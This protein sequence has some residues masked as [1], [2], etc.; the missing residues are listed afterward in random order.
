MKRDD[1]KVIL[2]M[3]VT[4]FLAGAVVYRAHQREPVT[5]GGE[6]VDLP[7]I[8]RLAGE[9]VLSLHPADYWEP[10]EEAR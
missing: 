3:V 5:A 10:A 9:G 7:R 4:L 8:E 1:W 6:K 2:A